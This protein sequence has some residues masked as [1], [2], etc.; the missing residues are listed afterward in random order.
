MSAKKSRREQ[1]FG[2]RQPKKSPL[3]LCSLP[4]YALSPPLRSVAFTQL[5]WSYDEKRAGISLKSKLFLTEAGTQP[6]QI[7]QHFS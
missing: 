3:P 4:P 7:F 1:D 5:W 2:T 6:E